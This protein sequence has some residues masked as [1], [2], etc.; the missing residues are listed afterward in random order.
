MPATIRSCFSCCGT[1]GQRVDGPR[2]EPARD[3]EV[4][5]ALG[6]ALDERRGL[7]LDE[8]VG[9][10]DRV[11]RPDH[12]AA[13]D[14]SPEHR[15]TT[16]V[17]VA[18]LQPQ[19]LV[20]RGVGLVDVERRRLRLG[21]DVDGGRLE[22]DGARRQL[23]VLGAGQTRRDR[24]RDRHDEL[25]AQPAGGLVRV[26]RVGPVDHDLGDPV[27]IA[28]VEEDQLAVVATPVD[29]AGQTGVAAGIGSP[30]LAAGV[31]AVGRGEAGGRAGRGR[32][33]SVIAGVS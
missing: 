3:D 18:V 24:A 14:Q 23:R 26:R 11:D 12:R 2:L 5:G 16:D 28:Q 33:G 20:D 8:A 15:L 9:V 21:Q 19:A 7:D 27:T 30:K 10:M 4:A 1:L 29:P 6:R 32:A 17:E 31:A 25:R 13:E 22:L